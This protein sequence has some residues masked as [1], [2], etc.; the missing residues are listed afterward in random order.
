MVIGGRD[1]SVYTVLGETTTPRAIAEAIGELLG[2]PARLVTTATM[3]KELP[4]LEWIGGGDLRVDAPW[5]P[6]ELRWRPAGPS[7]ADDLA[8]GSYLG[9]P[10]ILDP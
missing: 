1:G 9:I 6:E 4:A 7:P 10:T 2:V 8:R 3:R 5:I